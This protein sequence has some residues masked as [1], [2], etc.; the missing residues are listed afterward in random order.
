MTFPFFVVIL[1]TMLIFSLIAMSVFGGRIHSGTPQ[2]YLD[3]V[4]FEL[5]DDYEQVN[6]NDL[7]NCVVYTHS[8]TVTYSFPDLVNMS[9]VEGQGV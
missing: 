2:I 3:N 5:E 8:F 4:G 7:F 6:C 1:V 9:L